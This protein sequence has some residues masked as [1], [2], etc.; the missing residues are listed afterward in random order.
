MTYLETE[1]QHSWLDGTGGLKA[2]RSPP[3][4]GALHRPQDRA[5]SVQV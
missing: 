5:S 1:M 3:E 2:A 4:M